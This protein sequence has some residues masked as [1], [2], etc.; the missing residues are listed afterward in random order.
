MYYKL[1]NFLI[2]LRN[3]FAGDKRIGIHVCP[4]D[5]T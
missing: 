1:V 4:I 3:M 2:W 5:N